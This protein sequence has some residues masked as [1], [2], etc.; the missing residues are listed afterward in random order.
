VT[1]FQEASPDPASLTKAAADLIRLCRQE[2]GLV[3]QTFGR[4]FSNDLDLRMA[5]RQ[6]VARESSDG[7]I[8]LNDTYQ[9]LLRDAESGPGWPPMYWLSIRRL[10][11]E[12]VMDWRDLQQIKNMIVGPEHEGM[13]IFPAE[14]RLVDSANQ[15]HLWVFKDKTFRLPFGFNTRYVEDKH[16]IGHSQQRKFDEQTPQT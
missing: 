11:R 7:K 14:S 8:L 13:E 9:V 6:F 15:Y 3:Q 4:T 1:P 2:P 16:Q 10:D 5:V 12:P